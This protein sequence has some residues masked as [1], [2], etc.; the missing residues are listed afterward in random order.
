MNRPLGACNF[1]KMAAV[2]HEEICVELLL[3]LLKVKGCSWEGNEVSLILFM[4][5]TSVIRNDLCVAVYSPFIW[6]NFWRTE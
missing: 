4:K 6:S 3:G 1:G 2:R 5:P